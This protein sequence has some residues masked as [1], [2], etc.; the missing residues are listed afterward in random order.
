[1][2]LVDAER[3]GHRGATVYPGDFLNSAGI[4][5]LVYANDAEKRK[6]YICPYCG[7]A[8]IFGMW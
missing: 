7:V 1:M 8:A 2:E 3:N 6:N 5:D 4:P